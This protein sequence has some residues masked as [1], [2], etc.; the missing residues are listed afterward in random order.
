VAGPDQVGH[1]AEEERQ[2]QGPDV[3]AV[4]VGVAHDDDLV[5]RQ[6]AHVELVQDPGAEHLDHGR[7][8]VVAE[9]AVVRRLPHV[10]DLAAQGQ[11]RL[12]IRV[13]RA[14]GGP[15]CRVTL[16]QVQLA[17]VGLVRLRILEL[18][19]AAAAERVLGLADQVLGL[20]GRDPRLARLQR[21]V[22]DLLR[23][24]WVLLPPGLEVLA[25]D[26][27]DHAGNVRVAE[28]GLGLPLELRLG[29]LDRDHGHQALAVVV[30]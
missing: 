4:D 19:H 11:D 27:L 6:L 16:D 30:A 21:L 22:D 15:A 10:E 1:L 3:A 12:G 2:D 26:R 24:G 8:F 13:A 9:H 18:G 17:L 29:D 20:L 5:V 28:L 25:D 7:D 23:L 14:D